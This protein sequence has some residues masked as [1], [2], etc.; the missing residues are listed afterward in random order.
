MIHRV[1]VWALAAAGAALVAASLA[2]PWM[3]V[4]VGLER[5]DGKPIRCV[6]AEPRL[7]AVF[8]AGCLGF[9]LL[10]VGGHVRRSATSARKAS[11]AGGVMA[12]LAAYPFAAMALDGRLAAEAAWLN[13]QHE[14]LV[15]LGGDLPTNLEAGRTSWKEHI[16]LVDTPRQISVVQMPSSQLGAFRFG[17]LM[18]WLETLGYSNRF[19]QFVGRGWLAAVFGAFLL[20]CAE[21]MPRG[22]LDR[23]R[24]LSALG[25]T[26]GAAFI[27]IGLAAGPVLLSA[28]LLERARGAIAAGRYAEGRDRL[29]RAARYLPALAQDTF[30]VAQTG[31]L[32]HRL[33]REHT[34]EGRL[35]DAVLLERHG[36]YAQ[37]VDRYQQ[38]VAESPRGSAIRRE[39]I[40]AL[41]RAAIHALNA[42]RNEQATALLEMVAAADP[43][44]IKANY[45][46][47]LACLRTG[48]RA[49]LER[50][51]A[52]MVAIYRWFQMPTKGIVLANSYENL[53]LTT[54]REYSALATS[55]DHDVEAVL[56]YVRKARRP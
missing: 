45:A 55:P 6:T 14:N 36:H 17:R 54:S 50:L 41:M 47:Q 24:A 1:A 44:N 34:P 18:H 48:R 32:D 40:R 39:A 5:A 49:E 38:F 30:F 15:W 13:V 35:F 25:V 22:R 53:L 7:T 56:R 10:M 26:A 21:C 27:L 8:R 42:G 20:A 46:L 28:R 51:V 37:A 11:L 4:P 19:C 9:A 33:H 29:E 52:E 3:T 2:W 43:C 31:L 16:Y 12:A 23:G